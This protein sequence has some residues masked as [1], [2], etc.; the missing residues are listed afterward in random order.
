MED[1]DVSGS[2]IVV[3]D[4]HFGL[5]NSEH[6][7]FSY[8]LEW[9]KKLETLENEELPKITVDGREKV[10]KPPEKIILLGDILELWDPYKDEVSHILRHSFKPLDKVIDLACEKVYAVGNHDE[11]IED[12][13]GEY[14]LDNGSTFKIIPGHYPDE[15]EPPV[16][17]G[18][19]RYF[20]IHGHQFDKLFI[21]AGWFASLPSY[22]AK[23]SSLTSKYFPLN[24]WSSVLLSLISF[25]G[26]FISRPYNFS[27]ALLVLAVFFAVFAVTKIFTY[28]Q[29]DV[30]A[31]I[32]GYVVKK[33]K[34]KDIETIIEENYYDKKKDTIQANVIVFGHTHKPEIYNHNDSGKIFVNTGSWV[35]E[36]GV[37]YNTFVYIDEEGPLVLKWEGGKKPPKPLITCVF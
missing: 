18:K 32:R 24:G 6:E 30:W 36:E 3:S 19:N 10:L 37:E 15:S 7:Q 34:Y 35:K 4:I 22:M 2:I 33:P 26:Y 13:A 25:L 9:I 27:E 14:R 17:L 16:S 1:K 29:G 20:F 23:M 31:G 28:L 8:F 11:S 12:Y 5:G 21:V